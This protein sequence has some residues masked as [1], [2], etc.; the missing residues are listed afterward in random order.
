MS[1]RSTRRGFLAAAA[2]VTWSGARTFAADA[3]KAGPN[4]TVN[5]G[6]IGCGF[7]GQQLIAPWLSLPGVRI[8]A[9]C[10]VHE[11]RTE[12]ARQRAGGQQV[13][14]CR[15]FRRLL[16]S[17]EIDAVVITSNDHW[18]LLHAVHALQAG[19]NV[20]VE[21][22]LGTTIH[23]GRVVVEA[24]KKS[25]RVVQFGTWQRSMEHYRK[26]AE[27]VRSGRLG[28]V[29]EVKV[30]DYDNFHP[31]FGAPPDGSPPKGLDWDLYLGPSPK[32]PYNPNRYKMPQW[33]F[34]SDYSGGW[35]SGWGVHH[36]DI[37]HWAMDVKSP[38]AATAM[39]GKL[40]FP[41]DNT[42]LPDT[43]DGLLQYPACPAAKN[44]FVLQ[45]T[46]RCGCR[47]EQRC[48]GKWFFGTDG[49]LLVTRGGYWLTSETHVQRD[50]PDG[51]DVIVNAIAW[52]DGRGRQTKPVAD[53]SLV[54]KNDSRRHLEK[55]VEHLRNHTK[56]QAEGVEVGHYATVPGHLLGIAHKVR[57]QIRWDAANE[58][59][60]GD[61]EADAL[62]TKTYRAPWK[63][64]V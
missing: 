25:G 3:P 49:A 15:D 42:E 11:G 48:H 22:P 35:Q 39:G 45:Y 33:D 59:I 34:F 31:G 16:E 27:I 10:D 21:K 46:Y 47:R 53:E 26:A 8:A 6:M 41:N 20:Y 54:T 7:R 23:E 51:G 63:L 36:F 14:G 58:R 29:S 56:P 12:Q 57:R 32:T 60:P 50:A 2:A 28:Q 62:L 44:G 4:E 38:V 37:V 40:A 52:L 9:V 43:L 30:W 13:L 5:L 18:H 61:P 24:A 17:K 64:E 1:M 55:F 19:K